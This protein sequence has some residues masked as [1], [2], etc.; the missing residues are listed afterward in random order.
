MVCAVAAITCMKK[1]K[2]DKIQDKL[3]SFTCILSEL[4][5]AWIGGLSQNLTI[6]ILTKKNQIL[7]IAIKRI[8]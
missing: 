3:Y 2:T 7:K 5:K 1:M 6:S 4:R 8:C